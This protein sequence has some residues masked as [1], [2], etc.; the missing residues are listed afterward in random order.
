MNFFEIEGGNASLDASLSHG[1]VWGDLRSRLGIELDAI[2]AVRERSNGRRQR[3]ETHRVASCV[4]RGLSN[5]KQGT[6]T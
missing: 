3:T 1:L 4:V 2:V 5:G 6:M